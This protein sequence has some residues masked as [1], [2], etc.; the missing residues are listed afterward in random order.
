[1]GDPVVVNAS[2]LIVLARIDGLRWLPSLSDDLRVPQTVLQE[3]EAGEPRDG[4]ASAVRATP[5]LKI[6]PDMEVPAVVAAW[7]IDP[8]ESQVLA[9]ALVAQKSTAF[10]DDRAARR[11][12]RS[13]GVPLIETAGFVALL[14]QRRVIEQVGPILDALRD[15]GLRLSENVVREILSMAGE[16]P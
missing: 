10:L 3:L 14:K 7:G 16:A 5:F 12:A 4:A 11:A 8:G 13:L 1:V 9:H 2:P 15:A 6:V